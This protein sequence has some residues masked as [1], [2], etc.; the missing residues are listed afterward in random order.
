M[1]ALKRV[2]VISCAFSWLTN[3]LGVE[4]VVER[5]RPVSSNLDAQSK[6]GVRILPVP[7]CAFAVGRIDRAERC[8]IIVVFKAMGFFSC[9]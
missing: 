1:P 5:V 9:K 8:F 2:F 4:W 6:I 7:G 3:Q